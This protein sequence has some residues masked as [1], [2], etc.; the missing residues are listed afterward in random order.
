MN[1]RRKQLDDASSMLRLALIAKTTAALREI[2]LTNTVE[3]SLTICYSTPS[4]PK[5]MEG[6]VVTVAP[7]DLIDSAYLAKAG[8]DTA[9][10]RVLFVA[11]SCITRSSIREAD[12]RSDPEDPNTYEIGAIEALTVIGSTGVIRTSPRVSLVKSKRMSMKPR[13]WTTPS[14]K[15]SPS[16]QW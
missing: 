1:K 6:N 14:A 3:P 9:S 15:A 4:G 13:P 2:S 11:V 10:K 12:E 16:T 7:W 5:V 8:S